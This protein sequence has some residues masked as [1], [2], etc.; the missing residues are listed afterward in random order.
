MPGQL[1]CADCD[2]DSYFNANF[3]ILACDEAQA[4]ANSPCADSNPPDGGWSHTL[5]DDCNDENANEFPGQMWYPDCDGDGY[6]S[7]IGIVACDE[8]QA[9]ALSPCGDGQAPDG[10]WSNMMGN[11]CDDEDA[12]EFPGQMWYPDCDGDGYYSDIGI[13]ACTEAEANA[14]SPCLDGRRVI[15][16]LAPAL[17]R[18]RARL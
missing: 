5:G 6:Y 8:A 17:Q 15:C 9:N 12:G 11:D 4:N 10:G 3:G 13:S 14:S 2:G 18:S 16:S 7:Y 1:W